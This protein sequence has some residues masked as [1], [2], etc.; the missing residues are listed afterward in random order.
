MT[1]RYSA[2]R[3]SLRTASIMLVF[4]LVFT[5]LMAATYGLTRPAIQASMQEA[6]MRLIDEV[7]PPGSYDND[8]LDDVVRVGPTPALG[9]DDG[10]RIWRARRAGQPVALIVETAATDGY[11]GR[12]A[13]VVA[14]NTNGL[15]SG[16]RVTAHKETPG[17]GDY[18]DPKKDRRK[19][20]PW[21]G[22]FAVAT[23]KNVNTA[24][25]AVRKD[26]GTFGYRTG[27]TISARAVVGA[28][29]RATAWASARQDALFAAPA[30]ST[31]G[32]QP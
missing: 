6:Q 18:I 9:L 27:A 28:V 20:M 8:L 7:L 12:I 29:G 2:T 22:Q 15:L 31:F 19:D 17:L 1:A 25:W 26:G 30:G 32:V 21:I 14:I 24:T 5:T 16:V 13:M 3:T 4:T 23:W 10:G 11:A